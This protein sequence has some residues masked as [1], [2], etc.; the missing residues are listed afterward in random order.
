MKGVDILEQIP[1]SMY[2][3]MYTAVWTALLASMPLLLV[4]MVVGLIIGIVQTATSIQ[5]QTLIFIPKVIAVFAALVFFGSWI[6][7]QVL[8]L[9]K[10]SLG[11]LERFIQ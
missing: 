10:M 11:Q 8:S 4:A 7:D 9:T 3:V 2:D 6:G 1:L 5:E